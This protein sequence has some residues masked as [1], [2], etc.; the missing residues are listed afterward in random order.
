MSSYVVPMCVLYSV[1]HP[2]L[3]I[4]VPHWESAQPDAEHAKWHLLAKHCVMGLACATFAS[5][6]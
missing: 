6:M 5:D 1:F 2:L 4:P 3:A